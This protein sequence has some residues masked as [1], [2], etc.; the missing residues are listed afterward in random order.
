[1]QKK[2][3]TLNIKDLK[4][5]TK[6]I[7]M[8]NTSIFHFTQPFQPV[9][10]RP[11]SIIKTEK[12]C[13][14]YVQSK[15]KNKFC[16]TKCVKRNFYKCDHFLFFFFFRLNYNHFHCFC[17]SFLFLLLYLNFHLDYCIATLIPRIFRMSTQIPD[18]ILRKQLL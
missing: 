17:M 13:A 14:K 16:K 15:T 2:S 12:L 18:H 1:M 5:G 7:K 4:R 11:K 9:F 6:K 10:T 3:I 8:R